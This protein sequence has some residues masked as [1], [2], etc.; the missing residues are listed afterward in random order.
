[1]LRPQ[2]PKTLGAQHGNAH[3]PPE[4]LHQQCNKRPAISHDWGSTAGPGPAAA[5]HCNRLFWWD[6]SD[7]QE[8]A[9]WKDTSFLPIYRISFSAAYELFARSNPEHQWIA[10]RLQRSHYKQPT[11]DMTSLTSLRLREGSSLGRLRTARTA[12]RLQSSSCASCL[13]AQ[14]STPIRVGTP[15]MLM[16]HIEAGMQHTQQAQQACSP[17]RKSRLAA[18]PDAACSQHARV[19]CLRA[20][21][22]SVHAACLTGCRTMRPLRRTLCAAP[23]P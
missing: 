2:G 16:L 21:F 6:V 10:R 11:V 1:M 15:A 17:R 4:R 18:A 13:P 7:R 20:P 8:H 19:R 9:S 14:P 22:H 23:A 3:L 12:A 5:L